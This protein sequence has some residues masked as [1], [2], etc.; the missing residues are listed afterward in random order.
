MAKDIDGESCR[1]LSIL[2]KEESEIQKGK[3][4]T[5]ETERLPDPKENKS[6][7]STVGTIKLS[8]Q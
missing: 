7:D 3:K 6:R 4:K 5:Q 2:K 8:L 1:C